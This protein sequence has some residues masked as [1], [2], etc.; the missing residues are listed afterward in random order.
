M[1][2]FG[3]IAD[4]SGGIVEMSNQPER[5]RTV[6]DELDAVGNTTKAATKGFAVGSA[7]LAAFLL[8]SAFQDEVSAISGSKFTTVDISQPEILVAGMLGAMMT[9]VFSSW[10]ILA[11]GDVARKVVAEVRRQLRDSPGILD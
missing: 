2:F 9:F 3:P 4:N 1:D 8:F 6:T 10:T 11:V 5:V 7:S